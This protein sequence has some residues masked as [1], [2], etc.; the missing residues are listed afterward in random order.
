MGPKG[1]PDTKMNWS[2]DRQ[3]FD[4]I[5]STGIFLPPPEDGNRISYRNV[6]V[7]SYLEFWTM[8]KVNQRFL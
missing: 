3:P 6:V 8:A 4:K 1:E 2:T 7:S 5:N